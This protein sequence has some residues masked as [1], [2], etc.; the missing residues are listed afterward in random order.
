MS[1]K[2]NIAKKSL[3]LVS[4]LLIGKFLAFIR[5]PVIASLFGA[6]Y[7]TDAFFGALTIATMLFAFIAPTITASII[8]YFIHEQ[9][10]ENENKVWQKITAMLILF[11]VTLVVLAAFLFVAAP[12]VVKVFSPGYS[13]QTKELMVKLVRI[14][15]PLI[16]LMPLQFFVTALLNAQ[17]RFYLPGLLPTLSNALILIVIFAFYEAW[18]INSVAWGVLLGAI[19]QFVL[20][21]TAIYPKLRFSK[22]MFYS[23]K[24]ALLQI[25]KIGTPVFI[26]AVVFNLNFIVMLN[27]SSHHAGGTYSY[28]T[29]GIRIQQIFL[30]LLFASFATVIFPY[31]SD[32]SALSDMKK[33]K[34]IVM[35]GIRAL[36]LILLPITA[37][38]IVLRVPI[39][40]LIYDRSGQVSELVSG[41][42]LAMAFFALS[43]V[44]FGI[45]EIVNRAFYAKKDSKTPLIIT[46]LGVSS[47]MLFYFLIGNSYFGIGLAL[48]YSFGALMTSLIGLVFVHKKFEWNG[49]ELIAF[50]LKA[51]IAS[52]VAGFVMYFVYLWRMGG[53]IHFDVSGLINLLLVLVSG[54]T[55]YFVSLLLLRV[56]EA[57]MVLE[58]LRKVTA[59]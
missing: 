47:S 43:L 37:M 2:K 42:S 1:M 44:A 3:V 28:L 21:V 27:L 29:Y 20:I 40:A 9:K 39:A 11:T 56:K 35:Y 15:S 5:G 48:A 32:L 45:G 53:G 14:L 16:I 31:L 49:L 36:S 23:L 6:D 41:V 12:F 10:K 59:K 4:L 8:P 38:L 19:L 51:L 58:F 24:S 18:G 30:D 7:K 22:E 25:A 57:R 13:E 54:V 34:E 26:A 55:A 50:F 33:F 17:K 46:I 52:I